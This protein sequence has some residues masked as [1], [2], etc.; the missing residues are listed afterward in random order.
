MRYVKTITRTSCGNRSWEM[1]VL[2]ALFA[3]IAGVTVTCQ[4]LQTLAAQYNCLQ[5]QQQLPALI[6]LASQI[7]ANQAPAG[8][9]FVF[10]GQGSP[11]GVITPSS[12]A[13]VYFD[14]TVPTEPAMWSWSNNTWTEVLS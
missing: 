3:Q 9:G 5:S 14:N 4:S 1:A 6:Y 10:Q 8:A 11:V 2:I 12:S 7:I 13:A